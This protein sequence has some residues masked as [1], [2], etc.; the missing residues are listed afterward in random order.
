MCTSIY[1]QSLKKI[2][3]LSLRGGKKDISDLKIHSQIEES[4]G[5]S[6]NKT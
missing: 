1:F 2:D 5:E 3:F 6:P 4:S